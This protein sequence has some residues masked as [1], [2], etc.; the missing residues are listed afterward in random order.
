MSGG[1]RARAGA[2]NLR[3]VPPSTTSL[4]NASVAR[5][6]GC[7]ALRGSGAGGGGGEMLGERQKGCNG[8]WVRR[9]GR[10]R[11]RRKPQHN[12]LL[13]SC[14]RLRGTPG[15]GSAPPGERQLCA[16]SV[17]VGV[18][19][20]STGT[21]PE[22][23]GKGSGRQCPR[24]ASTHTHTHSWLGF[25]CAVA[26]VV[27]HPRPRPRPRPQAHASSSL[28]SAL[29]RGACLWRPCADPPLA[30]KPAQASHCPCTALATTL[31]ARLFLSLSL[32]PFSPIP[33]RPTIS[34]EYNKVRRVW[35]GGL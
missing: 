8:R 25:G 22:A 24:C 16:R 10:T 31:A 15:A 32:S 1:V 33:S 21:H 13:L 7:S 20:H 35:K 26:A 3:V 29:Q 23:L 34:D 5:S 12:Q 19:P 30:V 18:G 14:A 17:W 11:R 9:G 4:R 2:R 6:T 28:T 27:S